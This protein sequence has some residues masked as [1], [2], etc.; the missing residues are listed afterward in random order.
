MTGIRG[1]YLGINRLEALCDGV[2]A[3]AM[4]LLVLEIK[5]PGHEDLARAGGLY[6]Y[7]QHLWPSYL[8]FAV[9][10]ILIG[11]YWTNHCWLFSFIR[12]TDHTANMIQVFFLMSISFL[13]F[14]TAVLGDY[15]NDKEYFNASVT[16][17][18]I[19]MFLP[20]LPLTAFMFYATHRRRLTLHNLS[21]DFM[22]RARLKLVVSIL[23]AS[24]S[25]AL[26]FYFPKTTII[27]LSA[28]WIMYLLPPEKPKYDGEMEAAG[29]G[30]P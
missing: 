14:T 12:S 25:I 11:I 2:F 30:Q 24:G 4:T 13:P 23:I 7:L 22:R 5:I 10:F 9:T 29:A 16:L 1:K 15:I 20:V 28:L 27:I 26:S 19:G 18:A 8:A 21:V 3:I 6:P 17:Y